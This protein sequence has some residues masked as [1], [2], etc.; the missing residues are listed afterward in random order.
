MCPRRSIRSTRIAC[1]YIVYGCY[2]A[3]IRFPN[4]IPDEAWA[5]TKT[6]VRVTD[7]RW[8]GWQ[9]YAVEKVKLARIDLF[10]A[11]VRHALGRRATERS[12][13]IHFPR[14]RDTVFIV[15]SRPT[16]CLD[17]LSK[18]VRPRKPNDFSVTRC[19]TMVSMIIF[20]LCNSRC[21]NVVYG[22]GK[23]TGR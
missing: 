5:G 3:T 9:G 2:R 6:T 22:Y 13:R 23:S 4:L 1:T 10:A 16:A 7:G 21:L 18:G 11:A 19:G 8:G 17:V 15:T 12:R 14:Y 20:V